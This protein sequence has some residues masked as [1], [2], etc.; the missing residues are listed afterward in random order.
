[1]ATITSTAATSTTWPKSIH[2][3]TVQVTASYVTDGN[4]TADTIQMVK[5][6]NKSTIHEV[7]LSIPAN[8]GAAGNAVGYAVGDGG[9][10]GRYIASAT[11]SSTAV[12]SRTDQPAGVGYY[13]NLSGDLSELSKQDTVDITLTAG[14]CTSSLTITL[15]VLYS[16][17]A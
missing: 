6:P 9:S 11:V 4:E 17:D 5:V 10:T 2:V 3:G 13:Y 15:S 12:V 16:L 8:I 14:S 7:L 1:M